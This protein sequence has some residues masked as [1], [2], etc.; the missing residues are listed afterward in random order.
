MIG[1]NFWPSLRA[2]K[3]LALATLAIL[4]SFSSPLQ[5]QSNIER[6]IAFV[7]A[8]AR[9]MR[10]ISLAEGEL[11]RLAQ[12]FRSA[13]DQDRIAQL[14]VELALYAARL[15]SDRA[16]QR[17]AYKK[18]LENSKEL[19]E[20]ASDPDVQ[21]D[22]RRTMAE[23]AQ[24]FGQFLIEE[25]EIA[26]EEDPDRV[27]ELEEEAGATFRM[28]IEA[29]D[30]VMADLEADKNK[31]PRN[32][33]EYCLVWRRKGA[34]LRENARAVKDDRSHL[35][36][37][38]MLEIEEMVLEIGEE[39]ALGLRGLFELAM[40]YEV[41][42]SPEDA[43]DG[44]MST[45]EQIVTTL[46]DAKEGELD[47]PAETGALLY[48]MM[49]EVYAY[50][51]EMLFERG[52][53][54]AA[55]ELFAQF[56]ENLAKFGAEGDDLIELCDPRFGHL[57]F[58]AECRLLAE[59]G[60]P[61]KVR[62]ALAT[63]QIINGK[64]PFDYVGIKAKSVLREILAAQDALVSGAL[65]FEVAKGEYQNENYEA[66]IKGFRRAIAAMSSDE[67]DVMG[68]EAYDWL[69]KSYRNT[70]RWL[71]SA[72]AMQRGLQKYGKNQDGTENDKAT[73]VADSLDRMVTYLKGLTKS[74]PAMEP[75]YQMCEPLV[76][77]YSKAG[78]GKIH[79]K[80]GN[81]KFQGGEYADAAASY[82]QVP[83]DY[84]YFEL[85][86]ARVAKAL[87]AAGQFEQAQAAINTYREWLQTKDAV[88]DPKRTDRAQVR[89][90]AVRENDFTEA[91]IAFVSAYGSKARGI[92]K[93]TSKYPAALEKMNAF[94]ANHG[95]KGERNVVKALDAVGRMHA[96]LGQLD[97]AEEAYTRIK[98]KDK[99]RASRLAT[100]IFAVYLDHLNNLKQELDAAITGDKG[101]AAIE[102]ISSEI[103]KNRTS[104]CN[105]GIDYMRN[106]PRPQLGILVNTMNA[107]EALGDWQKVDEVAKKTLDLYGNS[108]DTEIAKVIDLSVRP[109]IGE[110]LLEQGKFD[111]A[112]QMLTQ[113]EA[114]N[115]QQY[116]LKRLICRALGGWYYINNQG[117]GIRQ[118][119]LGRPKEAYDKYVTEYKRWAL[120]PGVDKY[121]LDWYRYQWE[122]YWFA[123]EAGAKDSN[124]ADYARSIYRTTI[125][126]DGGAGLK[127]LG[128]DGLALA[129]FFELNPP[130]AR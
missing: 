116:E 67:Q 104:L 96:D 52:D 3:P 128:A 121:S 25:L 123:R 118:V 100:V 130:T 94:V 89:E 46:N 78:V 38:A 18:A 24:E 35:I 74:D 6:E 110:A 17:T 51:G 66:A 76:L 45:I 72:L 69:G 34:L 73:D 106:A 83:A 1:A 63:A 88:L 119:A 16:Q 33:L 80:N 44:Y 81:D 64:H 10:L 57:T 12:I 127:A 26:R 7:R 60:D 126:I 120:R 87:E 85:A 43:I 14:K 125:K 20:R 61:D 59:S 124:Y 8:L 23:A 4:G 55:T 2:I 71:E 37:S 9:E 65:L 62:Q 22:S 103:R 86:K 40:C 95:E 117:R 21:R 70:D 13:G 27:K 93:D 19:L 30:K 53:V 113:A 108:D 58:L 92:E 49:Q 129:K 48:D 47:L 75:V 54:E 79:W 107:F 41:A 122:A 28:G 101:T 42:D 99:N 56:R 68:L 15:S 102:K 84:L 50:L 97:Q 114:A 32:L 112:Y 82:Q 90:L 31:S 105:L 111:Q 5:A 77:Q 115:P 98:N 29:C 109:K 39:N 36:D 11:E 91:R